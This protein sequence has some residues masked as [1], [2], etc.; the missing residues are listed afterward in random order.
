MRTG[1]NR[2]AKEWAQRQQGIVFRS[3]EKAR[4]ATFMLSETMISWTGGGEPPGDAVLLAAVRCRSRRAWDFTAAALADLACHDSEEPARFVKLFSKMSIEAADRCLSVFHRLTPDMQAALGR[5]ALR[6]R[7]PTVRLSMVN[8]LFAFRHRDCDKLLAEIERDEN[9]SSVIEAIR[10]GRRLR[11]DG[12]DARFDEQSWS[13]SV[14]I[15]G[16]EG[17]TTLCDFPKYVVDQIGMAEAVNTFRTYWKS[18]KTFVPWNEVV[19]GA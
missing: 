5:V 3:D 11:T 14:S 12:Y 7:S 17:G 9:D 2:L 1:R 6:H 4:A 16:I 8:C 19:D 13:W 15:T 18:G 10:K